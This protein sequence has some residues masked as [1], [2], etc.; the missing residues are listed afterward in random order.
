MHVQIRIDRRTLPIVLDDTPAA[1]DFAAQLPLTLELSDYG[2]GTEKIA[3][4]PHRLDVSAEPS[5]YRPEAGDVSFYGPWGNLAIFLRG[6]RH[7]EGLVRLGRIESGLDVL[8]TP[9]PLTATIEPAPTA[10]RT[11]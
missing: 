10:A 5:G 1:R 4:L 3:D 9:G 8:T 2:T 11:P 7:S 6:F